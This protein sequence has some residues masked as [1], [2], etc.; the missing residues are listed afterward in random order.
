MGISTVGNNVYKQWLVPAYLENPADFP[1]GSTCLQLSVTNHA[2]AHT[3]NVSTHFKKT[4]S[5]TKKSLNKKEAFK[6]IQNRIQENIPR[7]EILNE[8]SEQ[9]YDKNTISALIA[10]TIDPQTKEKY[11][12]LNN[13]L[14]GLLAL[15]II[16]KILIG[17]A[18]LSS[19]SPFLIPI[20]FLL[21][22]I[23]IWFALEVSKFKGYIYNILGIL[24]I[25]SIFNTIG[26]L[27]E[28]G[29]YGIIDVVIVVAICGLSFYLG[30]MMFP[31]YGFLGPKKDTEGNILL[32]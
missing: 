16:A 29:I 18:L 8:L 13:F 1:M 17:I 10:S 14:L 19:L 6:T 3:P 32:G 26:K 11:K 21:P 27:E 5:M 9:Y 25:A 22:I 23:T 30:K 28:S 31:N 24:A 12:L 2:T 15:T 7:Q 20:A 4:K